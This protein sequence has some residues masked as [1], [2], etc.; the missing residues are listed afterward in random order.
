M[1]FGKAM[2][3]DQ[4]TLSCFRLKY[5]LM[6]GY[7]NDN[8]NFVH[9]RKR[10]QRDGYADQGEETDSSAGPSTDTDRELISTEMTDLSAV[11]GNYEQ[12]CCMDNKIIT[13]IDCVTF[14]Q[15][16]TIL[17]AAT[18]DGA[19]HLGGKVGGVGHPFVS[20]ILPVL[21]AY[22]YHTTQ[23][24]ADSFLSPHAFDSV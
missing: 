18:C 17:Q 19:A 20:G 7:T 9:K 2:P 21:L 5:S 6:W 13:G 12:T 10:K 16:K 4:Q 14:C 3:I 23:S 24:P 8:S 1:L 15:I 11:A 22:I